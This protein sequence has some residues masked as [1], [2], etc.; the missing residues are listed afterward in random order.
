VSL[1]ARTRE[2]AHLLVGWPSVTGTADEAEFPHRL[3][4]FLGDMPYFRENPD[5]LVVAPI[6]GD[7]NGRSNVLA[8]VRG[9][10]S[11]TVV[12]SGHF[13]VVPVDD[14]GDLAGLAGSPAALAEALVARLE[15]TGGYPQALADLKS[16]AFVPGRGML[17][18]K[19]GVAAG[20]AVMEAF[21]ERADRAGNLLLVATPDEEEN[22]CGMRAAARLLPAY[23]SERGLDVPLAVNLDATC[24]PD[25]GRNG[26][27]V[28][29][30]TIGKLLVS[31]SVF[32]KDSHAC[33]PFDG[34][35]SAYLAAE[36]VA[37]MECTPELA[38]IASPDMAA[39]PTA[40][41]LKDQKTVYNVTTP[42][43]SFAFWNVLT[44]RR[45][46]DEVLEI[47]ASLADRAL[48]RARERMRNRAHAID[49]AISI[50]EV[51]SKIE[52]MRF[53]DLMK[54]ARANP[55]F[56]A[57]YRDEA[58][59]LEAGHHD[60]PTRSRILTELAWD[61]AGLDGAAIVLGIASMP[62]PAISWADTEENRRTEA[63]IE[64][65][66][67]TITAR[68]GLSVE[69]RAFFPAISDMSFLGPQDLT[70][71]AVTA[72]NS[73]LWGSSIRWALDETAAQIPIVNIGP[74]GRDYHHWLERTHADYTFRVLPALLAEVAD[75]V[76]DTA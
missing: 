69:K 40:L 76:L 60:L 8:L 15:A 70:G 36:L 63:A 59:R 5:D 11:R 24:D 10:G 66:M 23:L 37:E 7:P 67:A 62:Y 13:D 20:I 47:V 1:E 18:M 9:R 49:P 51:W 61:H 29:M 48:G 73:P 12:L 42:G 32:G 22:S 31:A 46:P 26:R 41:A 6:D 54:A 25:D 2:I 75:A 16:G 39:P 19:S 45:S 17:D 72:A 34:V 53:A 38:E 27:V 43:R 35:N 44:H 21:S 55:D 71:L 58:E 28:T 74:W 50:S 4:A 52:V 64:A 30:G 33:Y 56:E 3:A 65:A 14:Y 57:R 68:E